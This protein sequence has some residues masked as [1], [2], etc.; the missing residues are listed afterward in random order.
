M[1]SLFFFLSFF[2]FP[3]FFVN[4]AQSIAVETAVSR[5]QYI[6][7]S[8]LTFRFVQKKER[9]K[10]RQREQIA[11]GPRYD[12]QGWFGGWIPR[13]FVEKTR[14]LKITVRARHSRALASLLDFF[15]AFFGGC[16]TPECSL[17]RI[18]KAAERVASGFVGIFSPTL[19]I[20][21]R[22]NARGRKRKR[23]RVAFFGRF[24][25]SES[26]RKIEFFSLAADDDGGS[27]GGGDGLIQC[28]SRID[29]RS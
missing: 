5:R 11:E 1:L 7:T 23:E 21:S 12:R 20:T 9:K 24:P 3:F 28:V 4:R 17:G 15:L 29:P 14:N 26:N 18:E 22:Y 19:A 25:R 16:T 13:N 8:T 10:S 6:S 2:P 27:G